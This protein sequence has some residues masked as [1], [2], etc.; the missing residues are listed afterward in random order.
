MIFVKGVMMYKVFATQTF[1]SA[2]KGELMAPLVHLAI[3]AILIYLPSTQQTSLQTVFGTTSMGAASDLFAYQ[4]FSSVAYWQDISEVVVSYTKLVGY[5]AFI[6]GWI[7]LSRMGHSGNQP[8]TV[9]KGIIHVVGGILL[10]NVVDTFNIIACT[11]GY[12]GASC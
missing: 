9:G 8:G 12:G 6:R 4:S 10:V 2:Q 7:I 5:I 11:M 1:S 3:G